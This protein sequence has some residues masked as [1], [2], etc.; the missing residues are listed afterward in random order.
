MDRQGRIY[1]D[2]DEKPVT[3][4]DE[5][6]L[7]DLLKGEM[8]KERDDELQRRLEVVN[9]RIEAKVVA[10]QLEAR[11][12]DIVEV[13]IEGLLG[14][15]D[16]AVGFPYQSE[17]VKTD[18]ARRRVE[19][20]LH[21]LG[22]ELLG[23]AALEEAEPVMEKA[24]EEF[25][26]FGAVGTDGMAHSPAP[27]KTWARATIA[28]AMKAIGIPVMQVWPQADPIFDAFATAA[29]RCGWEDNEFCV[30][31]VPRAPSISTDGG[32]TYQLVVETGL[33]SGLG[34]PRHVLDLAVATISDL[35]FKKSPEFV[36]HAVRYM[37]ELIG[38]EFVLP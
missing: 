19:V 29:S 1:E 31:A 32:W 35:E 26:T 23:E 18:W 20:L 15:E 36:E 33:I 3:K 2:T 27:P 11:R 12:P 22:D 5:Q 4:E 9:E 24:Y 21:L 17:S 14:I 7:R 37:C 38:R 8:T 6:R 10:E 16:P 13:L 34:K 30:C 28:A 25:E